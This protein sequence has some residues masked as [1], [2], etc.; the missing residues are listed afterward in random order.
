MAIMRRRHAL[1]PARTRT[2]THRM[3]GIRGGITP[4]PLPSPTL[5]CGCQCWVQACRG[6]EY[7]AE[8]RAESRATMAGRAEQRFALFCRISAVPFPI[9]AANL[10]G[11]RTWLPPIDECLRARFRMHL[12]PT[13]CVRNVFSDSQS[14]RWL[15]RAR[16]A[17]FGDWLTWRWNMWRGW[18][19][20]AVASSTRS[21]LRSFLHLSD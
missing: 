16:L 8:R 2:P 6:M 19:V 5:V 4:S 21:S 13:P 7:N 18:Q 1:Q 15:P 17:A 12:Y 11:H 14:I 20:R 10:H 3:P 9:V